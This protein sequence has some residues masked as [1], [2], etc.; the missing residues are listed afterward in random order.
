DRR[1]AARPEDAPDLEA[2][3]EVL[4]GVDLRCDAAEVDDPPDARV[5]SGLGEG[6]RRVLVGLAVALPAPDGVHEVVGGV[7][8]GEG[9]WERARLEQVTTDD[10][11]IG[12]RHA[13][14]VTR[15]RSD[16]LAS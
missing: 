9:S 8:A 3:L 16:C 2:A 7:D 11:D 4:R 12:A 14:D 1:D 5:G 6:A 10:L 15:A 13:V